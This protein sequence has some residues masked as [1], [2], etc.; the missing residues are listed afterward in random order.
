MATGAEAKTMKQNINTMWIY[1]AV[2]D[3]EQ[4][5]AQAGRLLNS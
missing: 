2:D 1:P 4:I 3:P 5:L